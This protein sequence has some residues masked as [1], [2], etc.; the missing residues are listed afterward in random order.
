MA[1]F[2]VLKTAS[3][4][5]LD[6]LYP[7][8]L[9]CNCCGKITDN[10]R[11]Y[12]LCNDC[13]SDIRWAV[14]RTC[15][16]C[17]KTLSE[18]DPGDVCFQCKNHE[19]CF[20]R[21]YSC[22]EYGMLEKNL[23]Y[24]LKYASRGDIGLAIGEIVYDRMAAEFG[25]DNL[26]FAYDCVIPIPIHRRRKEKR[27]FNQAELIAKAFAE[28]SG[29]KCGPDVLIRVKETGAMKGL[30]P[31]ERKANIQNAFEV[32]EGKRKCVENARILLIDDIFTTGATMD[33]AARVLKGASID[34]DGLACA[35]AARVDFAVFA[36][37][38]DV[39]IS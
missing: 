10:T 6:L 12:G 9:Y 38:A 28:K 13:M 21:G 27:G 2:N 31:A 23:L 8:G 14:G 19:H 22:A 32:R 4:E 29:I 5:L 39:L 24:E 1:L 34:S 36:S 20:D 7:P 17:G 25:E 37:G 16:K 3:N 35:G 33:E 30:G 18:G 26:R 15:N 11:T